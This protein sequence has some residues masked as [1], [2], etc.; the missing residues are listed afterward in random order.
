MGG[1]PEFLTDTRK[2]LYS[3]PALQSRLADSRFLG[4]GLVDYSGPVLRLANLT[5]LDFAALLVKLRDVYAYG[6]PERYLVPDEALEAF[7]EHCAQAIGDAYFR[8][9][10][11]TIREFVRLLAVLEQNPGTSWRELVG[12]VDIKP[13]PNPDLLP[14]PEDEDVTNASDSEMPPLDGPD[15]E[16]ASFRL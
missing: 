7:M 11:D 15:D 10:R 14:L 5:K 12:Q 2:G 8:T 3:Y 13:E 4:E 16:L 9:P 1:T 6:D